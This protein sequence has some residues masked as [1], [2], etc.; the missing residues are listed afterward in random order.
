MQQG[1]KIHV[2]QEMKIKEKSRER[3]K[4]MLLVRSGNKVNTVV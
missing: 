4:V 1:A 2:K 3:E